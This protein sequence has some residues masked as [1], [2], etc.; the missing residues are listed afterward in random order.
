ML[1][2]V[3]EKKM[4]IKHMNRYLASFRTRKI[5]G[6]I[7]KRQHFPYQTGKDQNVAKHSV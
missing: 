6:K 2:T 1:S 5:Q 4:A 3:K 7:M